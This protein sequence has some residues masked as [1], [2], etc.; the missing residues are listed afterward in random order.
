MGE[1]QKFLLNES[2]N[3][4]VKDILKQDDMVAIYVEQGISHKTIT[5]E[6]EKSIGVDREDHGPNA[7]D[8]GFFLGKLV[9]IYRVA[10]V[11]PMIFVGSKRELEPS[12][13]R[14]LAEKLNK[15]VKSKGV[16]Y[17]RI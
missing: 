13:T 12:E 3:S 5:N 11:N 17:G 16:N 4:L 8:H 2:K 10:S 14:P 6:I 9:N 1:F 7:G 15:I